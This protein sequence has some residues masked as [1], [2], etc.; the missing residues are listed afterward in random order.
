M[1]KNQSEQEQ[2]LIVAETSPPGEDAE[3][4]VRKELRSILEQVEEMGQRWREIHDFIP[5]SELDEK[6]LSGEAAPDF[7]HIARTTLE[8][9][10]RD[11][12]EPLTG[13]LRQVINFE[14]LTAPGEAGDV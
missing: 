8:C 13:A 12:L 14:K 3:G 7:L 5:V 1:H 10:E 11:H 4:R 6:M 9:A 2:A